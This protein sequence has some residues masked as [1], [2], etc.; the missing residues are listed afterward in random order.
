[1]VV[2]SNI[3]RWLSSW[4]SK[5]DNYLYSLNIITIHVII[6]II[7]IIMLAYTQVLSVIKKLA[8]HGEL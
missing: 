3:G 6:V 4:E 5:V 8:V 1:M 2:Y 7:L